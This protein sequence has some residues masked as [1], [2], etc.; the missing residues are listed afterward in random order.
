MRVF[1]DQTTLDL[2][3]EFW[4]GIQA[5]LDV[6][7]HFIL[8]ASPEAAKSQWVCQEI[9]HWLRRGRSDKLL[10]TLTNGTIVWDN[11]A[12]EFDWGSTTALPETMR[13]VFHSAPDY[14]DFTWAKLEEQVTLRDPR[15]HDGCARLAAAIHGIALEEL[16]GAD[17]REH[18][19][20]WVAIWTA[21]GLLALLAVVAI[22][23]AVSAERQRIT[24][25]AQKFA[26]QS[27]L[28]RRADPTRLAEAVALA[29]ISVLKK[30]TPEGWEALWNGLRFLPVPVAMVALPA[31]AKVLAFDRESRNAAIGCDNGSL[32]LL[33][34]PAWNQPR[35]RS[36]GKKPV[37][38]MLFNE[39]EHRLFVGTE[40]ELHVLRLPGLEVEWS[41]FDLIRPQPLAV[42]D[43]GRALVYLEGRNCRYVDVAS[44]EELRNFSVPQH[45]R[46]ISMASDE[47][48]ALLSYREGSSNGCGLWDLQTTQKIWQ[49]DSG[50]RDV[51]SVV[52]VSSSGRRLGLYGVVIRLC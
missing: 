41:H 13:G 31:E 11:A 32:L 27:E 46:F 43:C 48:L 3:P 8:L 30:P 12:R 45:Y 44:Q 28:L 36:L 16:V 2:T 26:A 34:A 10:L 17:K 50:L 21:L 24:A 39:N 37:I 29:R 4:P 33:S 35:L 1:R 23:F 18:R 38:S 14:V 51:L 20:T 9:D 5:A 42:A 22:V 52:V 6:S 25:E 19:R 15:F 47:A 49:D 7:G 40:Q